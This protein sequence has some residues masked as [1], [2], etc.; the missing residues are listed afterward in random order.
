M[1]VVAAHVHSFSYV[2][3]STKRIVSTCFGSDCGIVADRRVVVV[4]VVVVE[5]PDRELGV[6]GGGSMKLC[7]DSRYVK[8]VNKRKKRTS[9]FVDRIIGCWWFR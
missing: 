8:E 3:H 6:D 1:V 9:R 5:M 2:P 7:T 4:V